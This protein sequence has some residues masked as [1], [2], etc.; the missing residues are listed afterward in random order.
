M[1]K[2]V[3]K[4]EE[5]FDEASQEFFYRWKDDVVLNLE[6]SLLS[7]SK[8]ES[9]WHKPFLTEEQRTNEETISYIQCMTI[10]QNV[11]PEVYKHID[12]EHI[13]AVN[14]Y[15][16]DTMTAT[17]FSDDKRGGTGK[18]KKE[19]LTAELIYYY[20]IQAQIPFECQKWHLNR[21]LTLIR[22]CGIKNEEQQG[23]HSNKDSARNNAS[24]MAARR[25]KMKKPH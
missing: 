8:W 24:L 3:I 23:K 17:W 9:I 15:I 10:T 22:V 25:A 2:L 5:C 1:L 18:N 16:S 6:H 12:N 4:N 21:L 7:L 20:M 14:D 13:K 19:I 11:D